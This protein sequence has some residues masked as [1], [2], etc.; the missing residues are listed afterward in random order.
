[1]DIFSTFLLLF[2]YQATLSTLTYSAKTT[3]FLTSPTPCIDST[4]RLSG[5][6]NQVF[7]L[8]LVTVFTESFLP[9]VRRNLMTFTFFT[10]RHLLNDLIDY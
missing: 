8:L 9:F 1:M 10:A 2:F 4:V 3:P 6:E 5:F 7:L